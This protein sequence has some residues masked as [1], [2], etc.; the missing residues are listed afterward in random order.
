[1]ETN[2]YSMDFFFSFTRIFLHT[3]RKIP[4]NFFLCCVRISRIMNAKNLEVREGRQEQWN[5]T[6][7]AWNFFF[8]HENFSTYIQKDSLQFFLM[9]CSY[10]QNNQCKK[11]S[12][13]E[14]E[15]ESNG[16]PLVQHGICFFFHEKF[17][18]N[19]HSDSFP[20]FIMLYSYFLNN[21]CRKKFEIKEETCTLKQWKPTS[22]QRIW[23]KLC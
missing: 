14:R 22:T 21:E 4:Y 10:F 9:L 19:I 20:F 7:T 3:F 2:F 8:F 13:F 5:P 15:D 6:S 17:P 23:Q 11:I 16:I 18:V 1:M 12:K